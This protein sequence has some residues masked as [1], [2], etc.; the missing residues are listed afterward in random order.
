MH[1]LHSTTLKISLWY[2]KQW[3]LMYVRHPSAETKKTPPQISDWQDLL[4]KS[5]Q[6]LC[7]ALTTMYLLSRLYQ[8]IPSIRGLDVLW[9]YLQL[10]V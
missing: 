5:M 7:P 1:S 4:F 10:T 2:Q 6:F 3:Y 9:V 8:H